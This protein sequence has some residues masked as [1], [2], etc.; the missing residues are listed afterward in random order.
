[1]S[2]IYE[3]YFGSGSSIVYWDELLWIKT[4]WM[5][6]IK[7]IDLIL[8]CDGILSSVEKLRVHF[9]CGLFDR[10]G[11]LLFFQVVGL[12]MRFAWLHLRIIGIDWS[13][14]RFVKLLTEIWFLRLR[15]LVAGSYLIQNLLLILRE[16]LWRLISSFFYL[17]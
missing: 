7:S 6:N 5:R 14:F 12:R 4:K 2:Y 13:D 8:I 17:E 3:L 11:D 16:D 1:M 10:W 15:F 9:Q